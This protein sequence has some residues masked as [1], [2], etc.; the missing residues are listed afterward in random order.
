MSSDPFIL[1]ALGGAALAAIVL[2]WFLIRRP[3]ITRSVKVLL[4]F[5]IGILP[6]GT[7]MT[8]NIAG[9][10]ATMTRKFCSAS[11][12]VMVPYTQDSDDPNSLSLAA[13]HGRNAAFGAE[14]CYTCHEDYGMFGT[15]TTKIGGMRH[16]YEYALHYH[17]MPIAQSLAVIQLRRPFSNVTCMR[18]HSTQNP[19]WLKVG[20]HASLLPK[21]RDD[22]VSCASA[23][24]HGPAH[25]FS[26]HGKGVYP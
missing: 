14:N 2:V 19:L 26:Q 7:A 6:I 23:G 11:C 9:Y 15:I 12:H 25:P 8:G 4:L 24:C 5:G 22:T 18:C 20:D 3:A 1:A 17:D 16:V 13:R 21:L 10:H